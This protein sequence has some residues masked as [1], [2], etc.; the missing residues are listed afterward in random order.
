VRCDDDGT[1]ARSTRSLSPIRNHLQGG[2]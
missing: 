2:A 1:V